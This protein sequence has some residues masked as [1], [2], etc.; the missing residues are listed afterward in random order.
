MILAESPS[1]QRRLLE[2]EQRRDQIVDAACALALSQG[3]DQVTVDGVAKR[4][5]LSR[6][7]VYLYFRDKRELHAA[8]WERAAQQ[9]QQR[10][11]EAAGRHPRGYDQLEAIGR[12][13]VA[14]AHEFPHF[15]EAISRFEASEPALLDRDSA[16]ARAIACNFDKHGLMVAVIQRGLADGS[17]RTDVGDPALLAISLWGF[18]H[19]ILQIAATK[20]R[21]L[22][23]IDV[24]ETALT[25]QAFSLMR[26][27]VAR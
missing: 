10:F 25:E 20:G 1:Q 18:T 7:L 22:A 15:F 19:G 26:Q 8:L 13:Y 17:I 23:H 16:E 4:A 3:W 6:A 21:Q 12:A 24:A 27:A 14:F 9:L 5:R 11:E 2:R